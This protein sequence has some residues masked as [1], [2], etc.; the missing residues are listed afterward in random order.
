MAKQNW[1]YE[2]PRCG[3]RFGAVLSLIQGLRTIRCGACKYSYSWIGGHIGPLLFQAILVKNIPS[4][5]K[6]QD[7]S[8]VISDDAG[9]QAYIKELET[10]ISELE[11]D[12][13]P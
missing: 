10:K 1:S 6:P 11:K 2:C 4:P 5:P 3:C 12:V 13:T 8:T 7:Q 9:I